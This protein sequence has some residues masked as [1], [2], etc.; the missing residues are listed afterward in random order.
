MVVHRRSRDLECHYCGHRS[1]APTCCPSCSGDLLDAVGAGTEKVA[2]HVERVFPGARSAIL[3]RDTAR[4]RDGLH[5]VL[6]GFARGDLDILIGTQM[7]AKGHHFPRVTLTGVISAD[8]M[9][10][11]PD[12]RAGERTFQLLTQVAGRAGRGDKPGRV[13]IQTYYPDN[14]AVRHATRHDTA[15]F[16]A[17]ELVFRRSFDYPPSVRMALVRFESRRRDAARRAAQEALAAVARPPPGVRLWGPAAAP[18]ER[19]RSYWR[20]QLLVGA[21]RRDLLRATLEPIEAAPLPDGVRR[22]ID[23]DPLSTL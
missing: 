17:D 23:V 20:W 9:L 3:D 7:V 16:L 22:V 4:R 10:G 19:I 5:R 6:G 8:A 14:P 2:D 11:L 13:I 12:F 15:S 1:K 21:T 18:L